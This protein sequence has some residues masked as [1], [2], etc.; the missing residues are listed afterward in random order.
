MS[1]NEIIRVANLEGKGAVITGAAGG[2]GSEVV[3]AFWEAG[4]RVCAVDIKEDALTSLL[5]TLEGGQ[6]RWEALDLRVLHTHD[7]LLRRTAAT[8]GRLDV[9]VNA[10]AVLVRARRRRRSDGRRLGLSAR[11]KSQGGILSE[12]SRRAH[13]A[14]AGTRGT[15]DQLCISRMVDRRLRGIHCLFRDEGWNRFDVPGL[16]PH[17][18]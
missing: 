3:R 18:R 4:A 12:S 8:F 1:R 16:E 2:I 13:H 10:A 17:L 5:S 9:L 11:P 14:R 6:H 7:E 15:L